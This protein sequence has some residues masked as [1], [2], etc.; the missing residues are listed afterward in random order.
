MESKI[1]RTQKKA[2]KQSEENDRIQERLALRKE[3]NNGKT[4]KI[5]ELAALIAE[6]ETNIQCIEVEL[7][8]KQDDLTAIKREMNFNSNKTD[9]KKEDQGR[10]S[11]LTQLNGP[12]HQATRTTETDL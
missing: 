1:E 10:S 4:D 5:K 8:W 3:E 2:D 12:V 11:F 6:V 9:L 7:V